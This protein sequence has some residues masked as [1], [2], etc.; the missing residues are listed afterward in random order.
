ML[1][2]H[3]IGVDVG[4]GQ[5]EALDWAWMAAELVRLPAL[6]HP[7]HQS[8]FSPTTLARHESS[9]FA[10]VPSGSEGWGCHSFFILIFICRSSDPQKSNTCFLWL[11]RQLNE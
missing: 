1:P 3:I 11:L 10:P 9:S 6:L 7:P 2:Q 5:I 4:V 8:Q